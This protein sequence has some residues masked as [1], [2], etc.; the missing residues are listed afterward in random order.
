MVL[1]YKEKGVC[2]TMGR[3]RNVRLPDEMEV[4]A[5]RYMSDNK[6]KF[7][8]LVIS[9]ITSIIYQEVKKQE[10]KDMPDVKIM[11]VTSSCEAKKSVTKP[12]ISKE[13]ETSKALPNGY[14]PKSAMEL[15]E[16][17]KVNHP[18]DIC[19]GCRQFNNSCQCGATVYEPDPVKPVKTPKVSS[20]AAPIVK[21]LLSGIKRVPT[22]QHHPQCTCSM[23]KP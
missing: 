21:G 11:P 2:T 4:D 7:T 22:V 12:E 14:V 19:P 5:E 13:P 3:N 17:Y 15:R 8:D 18:M 16:A 20:K 1:Y 23:C 6:I 9:G 10:C